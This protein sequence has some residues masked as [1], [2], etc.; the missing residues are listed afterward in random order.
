MKCSFC[1]RS[2]AEVHKLV[3]GPK[4]L[5]GRVYICDRCAAQ[6]IEIM[7]HHPTD[8]SRREEKKKSM[9]SRFFLAP[10]MARSVRLLAG[11]VM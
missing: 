11:P 2:D 6:T 10:T 7:E 3:A 5:L 8:V 4:R 1:R 9:W